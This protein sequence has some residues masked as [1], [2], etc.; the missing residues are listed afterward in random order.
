MSA[1][2]KLWIASATSAIDPDM[3]ITASCNT[4]VINSATNEI[5]TARMPRREDSSAVSIE[6]AAS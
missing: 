5:F 3:R 2:L 4:D 6:S 1:S